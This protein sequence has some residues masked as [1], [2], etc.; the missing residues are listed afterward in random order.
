MDLICLNRILQNL[1]FGFGIICSCTTFARSQTAEPLTLEANDLALRWLDYFDHQVAVVGR[2]ECLTYEFC[3]FETG[4][5]K[6]HVIWVDIRSFDLL[7][8]R[9]LLE[10]CRFRCEA[11]IH[12]YVGNAMVLAWDVVAWEPASGAD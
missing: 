9:R 12:G 2:L 11:T 5:D 10:L 4:V 6:P 1:V 7:L 3:D 8:Q